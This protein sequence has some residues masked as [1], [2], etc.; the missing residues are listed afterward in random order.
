[1]FKDI[2]NQNDFLIIIIFIKIKISQ[3]AKKS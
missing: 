2:M 3:N 1:M